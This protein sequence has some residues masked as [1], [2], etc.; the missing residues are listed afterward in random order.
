M[1]NHESLPHSVS[2]RFYYGFGAVAYGAKS[3]GF[4]Y[5]LL[6]F[7]S[8]VVGLP[9]EWVSFGIFLALLVDAISDPLVGYFSDN[10]HSRWGRRHPFMYAAGIPASLAYYFL[11]A[12]PMELSQEQLFLYFVSLAIIIRT[13]LTFYEI[14]STALAAEL[15]ED[16][17]ERTRFMGARFFFGW[18]GG[19]TMALLVY[20]VFLPESK[21]GM[22]YLDG[23]Q[24]Y[25]LAAAVVICISI[26]VSALGTHRHIPRLKSPPKR[27]ITSVRLV[28]RELVE[29]LSN[30]PF[31]TLFASGLFSAMA[32]GVNT[33]LGIYF[34][35]HFWE[36][37][38]DQMGIMQIPYFL[39]ALVALFVAPWLARKIEK[40]YATI[41][42]A[43]F[44]LIL[45]P[46]PVVLRLLGLFPENGTPELFY[47]LIIFYTVDVAIMIASGILAAS[48]FAD[49][50]EDSELRTGRRSEGTFFAA[51]SFAQKAINGFGVIVAGQILAMINFPKDAKPGSV[52]EP[53]LFELA[54]AFAPAIILF[55]IVSICLL[56][57]YRISR[58][59]HET[60]V[61]VLQSREHSNNSPEK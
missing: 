12:P 33:S 19:L 43:T 16:Y 22:E 23:W 45:T 49:V 6:F 57:F 2:T 3:N 18:W 36:L 46:L 35:R 38:T 54:T 61:K 8:Q 56:L 58:E 50:V 17:D 34:A 14:P 31:L 47:T 37:T 52:P 27:K 25:G 15:T 30:R 5:L 10:L 42:T 55:Y 7:Y 60:N 40:K 29:T 13:L 26:Y 39:S 44:A 59:Q 11:W 51:N 24:D 41:L 1:E 20:L 53:V 21:G 32:A 48:M 4:N 9:P 28:F